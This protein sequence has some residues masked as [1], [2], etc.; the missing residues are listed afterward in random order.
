MHH[1]QD[2]YYNRRFGDMLLQI[3]AKAISS[4]L[5]QGILLYK[6]DSDMFAMICPGMDEEG[7]NELFRKVQLEF[8]HPHNIECRLR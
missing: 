3:S 4:V 2:K 7:A 1:V 6:M 5:P 8:C